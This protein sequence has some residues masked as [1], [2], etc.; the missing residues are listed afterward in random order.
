MSLVLDSSV[1]AKLFFKEEGSEEASELLEFC[2][3][4]GISLAALE[5]ALYE[6]G[7]VIWKKFRN[8]EIDGR[9]YM[10][11]LRLLSIEYVS[12]DE[13]LMLKAMETAQKHGITYYDGGHVAL[14]E[15]RG[16][17]LVTE[18]REL[19]KRFGFSVDIEQ[20]LEMLRDHKS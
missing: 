2:T 10:K 20:A 13:E 17:P 3:E 5:L 14:A 19:L 9:K 1:L 6:V 4:E 7:N 11:Q 15:M 12:L 8:K 18:D 16:G